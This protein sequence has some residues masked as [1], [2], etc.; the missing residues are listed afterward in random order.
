MRLVQSPEPYDGGSA[1]TEEFTE[2]ITDPYWYNDKNKASAKLLEP[3][4]YHYTNCSNTAT[5]SW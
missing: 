4:F 2:E 1:C 5:A 3:C